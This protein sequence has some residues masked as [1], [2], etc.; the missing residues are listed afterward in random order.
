M[1]E[2]KERVRVQRKGKETEAAKSN[3]EIWQTREEEDQKRK[4]K[5][6]RKLI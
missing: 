4:K 6:N 1:G 2:G 3:I 5:E